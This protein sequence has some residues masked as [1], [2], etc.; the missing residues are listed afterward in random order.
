MSNSFPDLPPPPAWDIPEEAMQV[1][2]HPGNP[3][4]PL[5][6]E[7]LTYLSSQPPALRELDPW[8]CAWNIRDFNPTAGRNERFEMGG[9]ERGTTT[10][11]QCQ[12]EL[13][14]P[15]RSR[16]CRE[17]ARKMGVDYYDPATESELSVVEGQQRLVS[18][19]STSIS[20]LL[21][22]MQDPDTPAGVRAKAAESILDRTGFVKGFKVEA[23]VRVDDSSLTK[24][25][26]ERLDKLASVV[27]I[28]EAPSKRES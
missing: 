10:R 28:E 19:V 12:T 2:H 16:Y 27:S 14:D 26:H 21:E 20:T 22:V 11:D 4:E 25:I 7:R 6:A 9:L 5:S 24:T 13:A 1:D 17:H 8:R 15:T 18:N 3:Y 23:D